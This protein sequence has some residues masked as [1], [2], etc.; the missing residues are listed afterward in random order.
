VSGETKETKCRRSH[1]KIVRGERLKS[2]PNCEKY[3]P[4][5]EYGERQHRPGEHILQSW[6][7]PCRSRQPE[8]TP[9]E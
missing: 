9:H 2:C 4:L 6:C 3:L 8:A 1:Y 5:A 7:P